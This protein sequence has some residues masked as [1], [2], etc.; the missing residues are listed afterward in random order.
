MRNLLKAALCTLTMMLLTVSAWAEE[1]LLIAPAPKTG[2]RMNMGLMIGLIVVALIAIIVLVIALTTN[3][4]KTIGSK[5][6]N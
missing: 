3:I 5:R 1:I 2:D 6:R 4:L